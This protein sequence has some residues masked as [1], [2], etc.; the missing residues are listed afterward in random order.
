MAVDAAAVAEVEAAGAVISVA[1][2]NP[3]EEDEGDD[4]EDAGEGACLVLRRVEAALLELLLTGAAEMGAPVRIGDGS[5]PAFRMPLPQ[6]VSPLVVVGT[7]LLSAAVPP[8][9]ERPAGCCA[10][11]RCGLLVEMLLVAASIVEAPLGLPSPPRTSPPPLLLSP[12]SIAAANVRAMRS[13]S[14]FTRVLA[15]STAGAAAKWSDDGSGTSSS[16]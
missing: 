12:P 1:L 10:S 11:R 4:A 6:A 14:S 9:L 16:A 13:R 15:S 2:K 5:A 3:A 8:L 7:L